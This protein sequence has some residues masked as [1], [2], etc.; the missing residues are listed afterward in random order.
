MP[1]RAISVTKRQ[2][3][4]LSLIE[5]IQREDL[6]PMELV[7]KLNALDGRGG[8]AH[9]AYSSHCNNLVQ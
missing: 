8:I 5:N 7:Q 4:E 1:V 6:S 2:K 3:A 9:Q